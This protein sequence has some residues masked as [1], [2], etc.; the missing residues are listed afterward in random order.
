MSDFD[1]SDRVAECPD[2]DASPLQRIEVDFAIPVEM[3]QSEQRRLVLLLSE[4]ADAP[5]NQ[6]KE[7]VHWLAGAGSKPNWS[8]ADAAFLG[9]QAD[10]SAADKGEPT[11]D[12]S[13]HTAREN[14]GRK[15]A[16]RNGDGR[17]AIGRVLLGEKSQGVR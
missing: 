1:P 13:P 12:D 10:P 17:P 5:W 7:G 8:K 6:P 9:V 3:T 11:F 4:I 15:V 2:P 14:A 16:A